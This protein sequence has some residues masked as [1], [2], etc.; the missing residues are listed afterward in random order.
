MSVQRH[1]AAQIRAVEQALAD[2]AE[3]CAV[4]QGHAEGASGQATAAWSG[5]ASVEFLQKV[6]VWSAGAA[7]MHAG[8]VDLQAWAG[9]AASNYEAAQSSASITWAG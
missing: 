7:V 5:A 3:Y 9:E 8:A 4:L 6:S 1:D 2:L